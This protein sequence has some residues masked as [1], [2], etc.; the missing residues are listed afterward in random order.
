MAGALR[1][2]FSKAGGSSTRGVKF[3][4]TFIIAKK[5]KAFL[6]ASAHLAL[7][8]ASFQGEEGHYVG[9]GPQLYLLTVVLSSVL[10]ADWY[11]SDKW[12]V[13]CTL[14]LYCASKHF[15]RVG[16]RSL[17]SEDLDKSF[18][19]GNYKGEKKVSSDMKDFITASTICIFMAGLC[20]TKTK[21]CTFC[22]C[23][24]MFQH[25]TGRSFGPFPPLIVLQ[26]AHWGTRGLEGGGLDEG[27]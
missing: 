1:G 22:L 12:K 17:I 19:G 18:E 11:K 16:L 26:V 7:I 24:C 10:W 13:K 15:T 20:S 25:T 27:D 3:K 2:R 14:P 9:L 4:T 8:I 21:L 5:K 6:S 23:A